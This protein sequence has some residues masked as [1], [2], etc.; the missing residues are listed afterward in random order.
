MDLRGGYSETKE[1]MVVNGHVVPAAEEVGCPPYAK[2]MT[3]RR[4]FV[5]PLYNLPTL[6]GDYD[7][8]DDEMTTM[9]NG[10]AERDWMAE[11]LRSRH[12]HAWCAL[13]QCAHCVDEQDAYC[14][15]MMITDCKH[16]RAQLPPDTLASTHCIALEGRTPLVSLLPTYKLARVPG[17]LTSDQLPVACASIATSYVQVALMTDAMHSHNGPCTAHLAWDPIPGV[18]PGQWSLS[19]A[20]NPA[21]FAASISAVSMEYQRIIIACEDR[22]LRQG[23]E[24]LCR[25]QPWFRAGAIEVTCTNFHGVTDMKPG[26]HDLVVQICGPGDACITNTGF[27]CLCIHTP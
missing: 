27:Y 4:V 21:L 2:E 12:T 23:T 20:T 10:A 25:R 14:T 26:I 1:S 22:M 9:H 16:Q 5:D 18:T 6:G 17:S 13:S 19:I 15:L 3:S 24:A 8:S 11:Q 7:S